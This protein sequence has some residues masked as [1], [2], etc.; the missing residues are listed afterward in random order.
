MCRFGLK[1]SLSVLSLCTVSQEWLAVTI[2][3]MQEAPETLHTETSNWEM[4]L[5]L[6]KNVWATQ[7][8]ITKSLAAQKRTL[9]WNTKPRVESPRTADIFRLTH[10]TLIILLLQVVTVG[11]TYALFFFCSEAQPCF[12]KRLTGIV[13]NIVL[14]LVHKSA[15]QCFTIVFGVNVFIKM[16]TRLIYSRRDLRVVNVFIRGYREAVTE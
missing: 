4:R 3:D 1:T 6:I 12:I 15:K 2:V 11:S 10:W 5:G 7:Y 8:I 14:S 9:C 13:T 16:I